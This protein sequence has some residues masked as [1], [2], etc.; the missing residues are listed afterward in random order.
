MNWMEGEKESGKG[1]EREGEQ[2]GEDKWRE[3]ST[4][5]F[6]S[7]RGNWKAGGAIYWS[8]PVAD[9]LWQCL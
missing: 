9:Q 4:G 2:G 8:R 3:G 1:R 7:W 6:I 5:M